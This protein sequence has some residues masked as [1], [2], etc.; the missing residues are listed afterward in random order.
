LLGDVEG[1]RPLLRD[2]LSAAREL[3]Q[4]QGFI[5]GF[6]NLGAAYARDDPLRAA[7][8]LG[9]AEA[10]CEETASDLEPLESRVRDKAKAELRARLGEE[11]YAAA[12]AAGRALTLGDALALALSVT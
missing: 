2:G 7:R 11:A 5:Y 6:A 8:L 12:Y 3:G 1:A 9:R 4:I 10:L